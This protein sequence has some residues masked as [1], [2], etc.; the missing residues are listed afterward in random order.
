LSRS[1]PACQLVTRVM[2]PNKFNN[3]VFLKLY[4]LSN[5]MITKICDRS[6]TTNFFLMI[7]MDKNKK[8]VVHI[9]KRFLL[10]YSRTK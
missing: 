1:G 8:K 5:Y 4:V 10:T 2:D 7:T 6:K 3:L 9:T